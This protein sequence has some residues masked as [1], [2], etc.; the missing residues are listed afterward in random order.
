M[1]APLSLL[2]LLKSCHTVPGRPSNVVVTPLSGTE[3]KVSWTASNQPTNGAPVM[4]YTV[5]WKVE[6]REEDSHNITGALNTMYQITGLAQGTQYTVTVTAHN[7]VGE[8]EA[9][10]GSGSTLSG[11]WLAH[12]FQDEQEHCSTTNPWPLH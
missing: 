12:T 4:Y 10:T 6:G 11:K 7:S 2:A 1:T 5:S 9:A 8:S 3:L